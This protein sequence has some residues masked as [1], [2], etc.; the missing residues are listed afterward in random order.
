[1][2]EHAIKKVLGDEK[3][4]D[5]RKTIDRVMQFSPDANT[6][7]MFNIGRV[8]AKLVADSG[9]QIATD[10]INLIKY[11]FN[12]KLSHWSGAL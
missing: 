12:D 8:I 11:H 2:L 10:F 4:D 7:N 3:N 1:M 5:L 9:P 6:V